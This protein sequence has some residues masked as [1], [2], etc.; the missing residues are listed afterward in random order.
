MG[1]HSS[2]SVIHERALQRKGGEKALAEWMPKKP[3]H[4]KLATIGDDRCLSEMTR[5]VFQA[6]FVYRVINDKWPQFE[7]AFWKFDP[8]KLV[9]MSPEQLEGLGRDTRCTS[10]SHPRRI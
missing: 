9:L 3:D 7:E 2:F 4:K 1:M 10:N 6:G 8:E 5:C